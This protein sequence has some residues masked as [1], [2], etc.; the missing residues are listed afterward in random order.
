MMR[1]SVFGG[2]I[3]RVSEIR[4]VGFFGIVNKSPSLKLLGGGLV[5]RDKAAW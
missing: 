4:L 5:S 3:G 1:L 2:E